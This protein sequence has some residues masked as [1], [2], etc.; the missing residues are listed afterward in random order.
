MKTSVIATAMIVLAAM[1]TG[2]NAHDPD[3]GRDGKRIEH[4]HDGGPRHV[5]PAKYVKH[6][7]HHVRRCLPRWR[8]RAL[9]K[10]RGYFPTRILDRRRNVVILKARGW[11]GR[12]F[13][14]RVNRCNGRVVAARPMRRHWA[15]GHVRGYGHGWG[16]EWGYWEDRGAY[17]VGG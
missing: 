8:I 14:L 12:P 7:E 17:S 1:S 6:K 3:P 4:R 13:V 11:G 10:R 9:L 2:A 5:R 16:R 15:R